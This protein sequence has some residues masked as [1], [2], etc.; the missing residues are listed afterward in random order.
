MSRKREQELKYRL[1]RRADFLELRDG[2]RWG[3]RSEP[4][5][6]V[7]H[8]FDTAES[9]LLRS[10]ILLRIREV[11]GTFVLTIKFGREVRPG[12]FDS[13][14]LEAEIERGLALAAASEPDALLRS[15]LE[16]IAEL[17]RRTGPLQLISVGRLTNERV[18]RE[19]AGH[20]LEVDRMQFPDGSESH[21]LEIETE[22]AAGA[23]EWIQGEAARAGLLLEPMSLT[24]LEQL[25][26]WR[27]ARLPDPHGGP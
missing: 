14:E 6:Q 2:A 23:A 11:K 7:N 21:E 9:R 10:R 8:Y 17:L 25:L 15:P 16:P 22:D 13:L 18:R 12:Y 24:K 19:A 26:A 1:P 27:R 4:E 5:L 20:V 3:P